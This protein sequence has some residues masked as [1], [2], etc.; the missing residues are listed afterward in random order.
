MYSSLSLNSR[1]SFE[2]ESS[3]GS[4]SSAPSLDLQALVSPQQ[5][6]E[7]ALNRGGGNGS[8]LTAEVALAERTDSQTKRFQTLQDAPKLGFRFD[9]AE[10]EM[11]MLV[12]SRQ[13]IACHFD[14]RMAGLNGLLRG[15]QVATNESVDVPRCRLSRT[16]LKETI[17]F[18]SK[19]SSN[20][21][22]GGKNQGRP[23]PA[24]AQTGT[25]WSIIRDRAWFV[26]E[27]VGSPLRSR[28]V[29]RSARRSRCSNALC[30]TAVCHCGL[31]TSTRAKSVA[32]ALPAFPDDL[33]AE[34]NARV[35]A[36]PHETPSP[37]RVP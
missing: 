19:L 36:S 32:A 5:A 28:A 29:H 27:P 13:E 8:E 14:A 37:H 34:S 31:G 15:G 33:I 25:E 7:W 20:S 22:S 10:D 3:R 35:R 17:V 4:R 23:H 18:H 11:G 26:K 30:I 2:R 9:A 24:G 1:N 6:A 12:T 21:G 16:D